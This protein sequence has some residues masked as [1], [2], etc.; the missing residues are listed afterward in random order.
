M[1]MTEEFYLKNFRLTQADPPIFT[2]YT[3]YFLNSGV[4]FSGYCLVFQ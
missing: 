4:D 1:I 3:D 2:D